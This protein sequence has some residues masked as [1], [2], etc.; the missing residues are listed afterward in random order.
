MKSSGLA[1]SP[2]FLKCNNNNDPIERN[3]IKKK[4]IEPSNQATMQP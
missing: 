3:I 4:S 1:D 2:L